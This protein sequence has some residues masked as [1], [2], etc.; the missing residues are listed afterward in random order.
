MTTQNRHH[1]AT[2]IMTTQYRYCTATGIMAVGADSVEALVFIVFG[3][4]RKVVG[5]IPIADRAVF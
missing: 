3:R 1:A 2:V 4:V 5:T